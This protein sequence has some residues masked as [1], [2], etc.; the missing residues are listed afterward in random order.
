MVVC[1]WGR[2]EQC[3]RECVRACVRANADMVLN[4]AGGNGIGEDV[5]ELLGSGVG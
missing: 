4:G 1:S 2:R 5:V 3:L